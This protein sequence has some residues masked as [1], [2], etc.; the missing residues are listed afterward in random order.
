MAITNSINLEI[1]KGGTIPFNDLEN[2]SFFTLNIST[3]HFCFKTSDNTYI[4]FWEGESIKGEKEWLLPFEQVYPVEFHIQSKYV[5]ASDEAMKDRNREK[6]K[7][8]VLKESEYDK[9][10]LLTLSASSIRLLKYLHENEV[11]MTNAEISDTPDKE[12]YEL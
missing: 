3:N 6:K 8:V 1:Q 5:H 9:A 2:Y 10:H 12:Y 7:R 4:E 11:D